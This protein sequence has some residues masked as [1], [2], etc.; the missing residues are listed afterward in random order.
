VDLSFPIRYSDEKSERFIE[1]G[2]A[3][4]VTTPARYS[5][6]ISSLSY[7]PPFENQFHQIRT[8]SINPGPIT[9]LVRIKSGASGPPFPKNCGNSVD[10]KFISLVEIDDDDSKRN[11]F[12]IQLLIQNK[13][14]KKGNKLRQKLDYILFSLLKVSSR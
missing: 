14:E 10:W 12:S 3:V 5:A 7:F 9:S 4:T 1:I 13:Y 6:D 2:R 8:P 11:C